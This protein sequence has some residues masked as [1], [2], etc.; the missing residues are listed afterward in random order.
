MLERVGLLFKP[1]KA[2]FFWYTRTYLPTRRKV[3][4]QIDPLRTTSR[5]SVFEIAGELDRLREQS[6]E[7]P[8]PAKPSPTAWTC[9]H[10]SETSPGSWRYCSKCNTARA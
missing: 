5:T 3:L 10:C 4:D 2:L 6:R 9:E 1:V 8:L 7:R